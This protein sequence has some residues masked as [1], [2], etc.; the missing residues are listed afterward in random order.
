MLRILEEKK[1]IV[2]IVTAVLVVL[3]GIL[4]WLTHRYDM[5]V[6]NTYNYEDLTEYITLGN[7]KGIEYTRN[8][9]KVTD[10]DVQEKID[11]ALK[12]ASTTEDV[13]SGTV[14]SKSTVKIDFTGKIDGEEF[15]GGSSED[16]TL[17][18]AND[19]MI[20]GFSEGIVGHKVG[21]EFDLNLTFP[22]DYSNT[23]VA[24]KDV[25]FTIKVNAIVKTVTP[26]YNDAFVKN[27]TDYKT[28]EEYEKAIRKELK[29]A[30]EQEADEDAYSTIY[31]KIVKASEVKKYPETELEAAENTM[32]TT[33]QS[34]AESYGMEFQ[35]FLKQYLNMD[36]STFNK[37]VK[38][39]AKNIVKQQLVSRQLARELD[40][41]ISNKEYDAYIEDLLQTN[42]LTKSTFK[43]KMGSNLKDYAEQNNLYDG[44]LYNEVMA[45]VIKL[46]KAK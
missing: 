14:G 41:E 25:T 11:A 26:E 9:E 24:G 46:C 10:A 21:D 42:G 8:V 38:A 13:T 18:I 17:D 22:S 36:E 30:N 43:D 5:K 33:Y 35:D 27:N 44:M 16:Y 29:E 23:D 32:T 37:K 34:M 15:D 31:A 2:T 7:Y 3:C 40:V 45:K 20:D 39:Y 6:P 1:L 19:S 12:E 4:W 28:T